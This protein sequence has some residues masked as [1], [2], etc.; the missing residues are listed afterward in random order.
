MRNKTLIE[1]DE[2]VTEVV[3]EMVLVGIMVTLFLLL[4]L[5][6]Y[7][8]ITNHQSPPILDI[9]VT[10]AG[11]KTLVVGHNGGDA[12]KYGD[13]DFMVNHVDYYT[14]SASV[15]KTDKNG[16]GNWD[17]GETVTITLPS[18]P[19]SVDLLV[20]DKSSGSIIGSFTAVG[21]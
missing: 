20:Y 12:V 10:L 4:T 6:V 9:S 7:S 17:V 5:L 15:G 11:P 19:A 18:A 21:Q 1:S 14:T 8:L 2:G 16:D 3:G 13:L